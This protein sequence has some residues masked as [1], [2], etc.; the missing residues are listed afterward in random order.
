VSQRWLEVRREKKSGSRLGHSAFFFLSFGSHVYRRPGGTALGFCRGLSSASSP[1][2]FGSG[3]PDW[4][5]EAA[6]SRTRAARRCT[7]VEAR[8]EI[9]GSFS[10]H[11]ATVS[12]RRPEACAVSSATSQRYGFRHCGVV[13]GVKTVQFALR[14]AAFGPPTCAPACCQAVQQGVS[15]SA[16]LA[17]RWRPSGIEYVLETRPEREQICFG[18]GG[19]IFFCSRGMPC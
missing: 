12:T 2:I 15:S 17:E 19:Q 9:A 3:V 14:G 5:H 4:N 18:S 6:G 8:R 13:G 16:L 7:P 1:T 11:I 10:M